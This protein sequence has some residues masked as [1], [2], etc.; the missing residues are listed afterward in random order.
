M[1]RPP[2]AS[3]FVGDDDADKDA[4]AEAFLL[5][6]GLSTAAFAL[7]FN[8]PFIVAP[9]VVYTTREPGVTMGG[10][11]AAQAIAN[12][13]AT[14]VFALALKLSFVSNIPTALRLGAGCG[15][16]MLVSVLGMRGVGLLSSGSFALQPVTWQ[17]VVGLL[18]VTAACCTT[19]DSAK[20]IKWTLVVGA[21]TV[22]TALV[23]A[24][25][26][27]SMFEGYSSSEQAPLSNWGNGS[28]GAMSFFELW[29]APYHQAFYIVR[30]II[31]ITLNICSILLVL[32]DA[33]CLE[34]AFVQSMIIVF[35]G[36]KTGLS[37]AVTGV[38]I[39]LIPFT[40]NFVDSLCMAAVLGFLC[41]VLDKLIA[42]R[43]RRY[44]GSSARVAVYA[45]DRG[46]MQLDSYGAEAEGQYGPEV[47]E[48]PKRSCSSR[49]LSARTSSLPRSERQ[50]LERRLTSTTALEFEAANEKKRSRS[51]APRVSFGKR[52]LLSS[53]SSRNSTRGPGLSQPVDSGGATP[54]TGPIG[55]HWGVALVAAAEIVL[56]AI[57]SHQ[58]ES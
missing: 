18:T 52:A 24:V 45:G 49:S 48:K 1:G 17:I 9:S 31:S 5:V 27:R 55:L 10:H 6:A 51:L 40:F 46:E 25:I 47:D 15:I 50:G 4:T 58:K 35:A 21:P 22:F 53:M 56:S 38:S 14:I 26:D 23:Y 33:V 8:V 16:S 54:Y 57:H 30:M 36:G 19:S 11:L 20:T 29:A 39:L 13:A 41:E 12:L 43:G 32:I 3:Q 37:A 42:R 2:D 44:S 7:A 28:F 34:A